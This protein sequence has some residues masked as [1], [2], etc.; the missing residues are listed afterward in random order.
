M[1]SKLAASTAKCV[2]CALELEPTAVVVAVLA[3]GGAEIA[4]QAAR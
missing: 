3:H 1:A 2:R 4:A